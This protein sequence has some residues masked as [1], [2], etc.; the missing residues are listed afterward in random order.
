MSCDDHGLWSA[1]EAFVSRDGTIAYLLCLCGNPR[2]VPLSTWQTEKT[3]REHA[4]SATQ[5]NI[6]NLYEDLRLKPQVTLP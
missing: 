3:R 4:A 1:T 2:A 5:T 6:D